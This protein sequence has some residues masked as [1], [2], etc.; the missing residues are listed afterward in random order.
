MKAKK[1]KIKAH[2]NSRHFVLIS[3]HE[4]ILNW[5]FPLI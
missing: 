5:I 3:Y 4:Y 1:I 2:F